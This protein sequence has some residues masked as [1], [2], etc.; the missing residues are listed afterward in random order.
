MRKS[1]MMD[2]IAVHSIVVCQVATCLS[3]HL[4]GRGLH[5][6]FGLVQAASLLHDITKTRSF[7]TGENHAETAEAYLTEV[8]YPEVGRIVGQHVQLNSYAI[9]KPISEAHIVNYSDKRVRH[10]QV[11][12]LADRFDY[13]MGRYGKSPE[14][15]ERI[16][17]LRDKT[18]RV[19][20]RIFSSI[21]FEP[22]ALKSRLDS[23]LFQQGLQEYRRQAGQPTAGK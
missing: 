6:D 16:R 17:L 10:D 8:G 15:R 9:D 4:Y 14:D 5:F 12:S 11:V 1:G 21:P 23:D 3:T 7:D 13:I 22:D 19:G 18:A 2:H 20:K